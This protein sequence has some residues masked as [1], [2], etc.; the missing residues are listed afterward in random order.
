MSTNDEI[1]QARTLIHNAGRGIL[2]GSPEQVRIEAEEECISA[3]RVQGFH[4]DEYE[5]T[6]DDLDYVDA[7]VLLAKLAAGE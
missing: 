4:G 6:S 3:A 2:L 1:K 7:Q 5:L